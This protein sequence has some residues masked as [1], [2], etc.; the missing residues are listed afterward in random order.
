MT[1]FK[2]IL[3]VILTVAFSVISWAHVCPDPQTSSLNHGVPPS[4]WK[5]NPFSDNTPQGEADARFV[6]ANV[7]VAGLGQGV[8][9]TYKISVGYY[10]IWWQVITKIPAPIDYRWIAVQGGYACSVGLN[11]CSFETLDY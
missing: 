4:P 11:E 6:R 10:S 7:L 8:M 5:V 1:Y 3:S 2:L 9:C